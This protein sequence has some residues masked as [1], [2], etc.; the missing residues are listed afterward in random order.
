MKS[1]KDKSPLYLLGLLL[2]VLGAFCTCKKP[3]GSVNPPVPIPQPPVTPAASDVAF[4]LT[5]GDGSVLLKEQSTSLIFGTTANNN[6]VIEVDT[7]Q[8]FQTINGFGFTLTEG[9]AY[10]LNGMTASARA[11]LLKELFGKD[12]ASIGISYL[13]IGIGATDLSTHV[14]SY[15]DL[16]AGTTDMALEKFSIEPDKKDVIPILK[17]ILAI[18]PTIK[19]LATPWSAPVWMKDTNSFVGGNLKPEYY[20][21]YSLYFVK[22]IEAMKGEGIVIDAITPQ[23][24]PLHPGNNPS[25]YMTASAQNNFIKNNLGPLFKASGISTKII[26]YDHNADRPDYPL[27]ILNDPITK[28]FVDGSAFHLYGGDIS[29]LSLVRNQH[30]DKGIYF[31]EQ[32]TAST[33]GF[34]GDLKWHLK[35]VVIGA[36]RNWAKVVLEWNLANDP[37][38]GP[39]TAGGCTTCLGAVTIGGSVTRNVGYYII[40][41]AAKFVLPGSVRIGSSV[42]GN[43]KN[44][45]FKRPDGKKV[46]IV[47]NDGNDTQN[48]N[49]KFNGK[50]ITTTL[51]AGAVGTYMW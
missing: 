16:P 48:F 37:S 20:D 38:F 2:M 14:Y 32:Y 12:P 46:L 4:W 45:A 21:V 17:E 31:T 10:V 22:Y 26:I 15:N 18:E 9:S 7:A 43:L 8:N 35:N 5:T 40:A 1:M 11:T 23:N 44:V 13:R 36:T 27:H 19:I 34:G 51:Q 29:A 42:A 49:L 24:E 41:H 50:W 28:T 3:S 25:M 47:E 6:P 33:G 30:P 39:H